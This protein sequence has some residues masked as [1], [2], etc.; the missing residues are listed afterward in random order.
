MTPSHAVE[1]R[2]LPGET[3]DTPTTASIPACWPSTMSW[4]LGMS[5]IFRCISSVN[6]P[7]EH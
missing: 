5:R 7:V 4:M 2:T 1:D 6:A 3:H